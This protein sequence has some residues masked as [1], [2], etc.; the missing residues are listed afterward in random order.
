MTKQEWYKG[1]TSNRRALL[2]GALLVVVVALLVNSQRAV[3]VK[4]AVPERD[5]PIM[6]F[7]HKKPFVK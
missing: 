7:G 5:V 6:V 1:A 3:V 4:V 2:L